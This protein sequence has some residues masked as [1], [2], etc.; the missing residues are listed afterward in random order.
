MWRIYAIGWKDPNSASVLETT[1]DISAYKKAGMIDVN[2]VR[3]MD[4][5]H[6]VN[7][8]FIDPFQ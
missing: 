8:P 2:L 7:C 6:I 3:P 5:D 4:K 1:D